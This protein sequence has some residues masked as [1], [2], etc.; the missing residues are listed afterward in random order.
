MYCIK[1]LFTLKLSTIPIYKSH[2]D[3]MIIQY[4]S[5]MKFV[6]IFQV[7]YNLYFTVYKNYFL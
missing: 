2:A 6:N 4:L 3:Y 1:L 5:I 7:I